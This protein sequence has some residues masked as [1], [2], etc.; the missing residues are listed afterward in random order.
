VIWGVLAVAWLATLNT[1]VRD[2]QPDASNWWWLILPVFWCGVP[3]AVC[4]FTTWRVRDT[5]A[6]LSVMLFASLSLVAVAAGLRF[7]RP[8]WGFGGFRTNADAGGLY[9]VIP[10]VQLAVLTPFV[11]I[12]LWLRTRQLARLGRLEWPL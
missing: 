12:A 6:A 4:G 2:S 8:C 3:S 9:L 1:M 7:V 5:K 11:G 10:F